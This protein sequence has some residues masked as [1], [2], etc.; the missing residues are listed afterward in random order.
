MRSEVKGR[1]KNRGK[2]EKNNSLNAHYSAC[3][4]WCCA[5]AVPILITCSKFNE[6]K[7]DCLNAQSVTLRFTLHFNDFSF[8][9]LLLF[10]VAPCKLSRS[11]LRHALKSIVMLESQRIH[12]LLTHSI[13]ALF[14]A[15]EHVL[16][17]L[18]LAS[19]QE[20]I[21]IPK[22]DEHLKDNMST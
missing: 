8:A 14:T 11:I 4:W 3:W 17:L 20:I 2:V 7:R 19:L 6:E 12:F 13:R 22:K 9:L 18:F 21:N 15:S 16:L 5:C 10:V 1:K